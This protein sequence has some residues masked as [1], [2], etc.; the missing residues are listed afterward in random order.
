[1]KQPC[2]FQA[3]KHVSATHA[4]PCVFPMSIAVTV[5]D[6]WD[7]SNKCHRYPMDVIQFIDAKIAGYQHTHPGRAKIFSFVMA[8]DT[9]KPLRKYV[10]RRKIHKAVSVNRNTVI[11]S[12]LHF[13]S[14]QLAHVLLFIIKIHIH[15]K[16]VS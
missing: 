10:Y 14:L 2:P 16:L 11:L 4:P 8:R 9:I 1:M 13:V 7:C 5:S 6:D 15:D 3:N 12:A